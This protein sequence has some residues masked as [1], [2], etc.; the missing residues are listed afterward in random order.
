MKSK[1]FLI[2]SIAAYGISLS[3]PLYIEFNENSDQLFE[4][5]EMYGIQ[6]LLLGWMIFPVLDFFCWLANFTLLI[7]WIFYRKRFAIYLVSIGAVLALLLG[8][9]HVAELNLMEIAEY[10]YYLFGYWFWLMAM[11]LQIVATSLL[12]KKKNILSNKE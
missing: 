7:S 6:V 4:L 10:R 3:L 2:A 12:H 11:L 5:T 1:Y 8:V 9:D